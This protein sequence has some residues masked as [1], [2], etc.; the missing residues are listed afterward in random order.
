MITCMVSTGPAD[1]N[2]LTRGATAGGAGFAIHQHLPRLADLIP[3]TVKAVGNDDRAELGRIQ[4]E[5]EKTPGLLIRDSSPVLAAGARGLAAA[6]RKVD[7]FVG[8]AKETIADARAALVGPDGE[9]GILSGERLSLPK[10]R[11]R[12]P[13]ATAPAPSGWDPSPA[14]AGR[15][16]SAEGSVW[17]A[18]AP[19]AADRRRQ[20]WAEEQRRQDAHWARAAAIRKETEEREAEKVRRYARDYWLRQ[21]RPEAALPDFDAIIQPG[22]YAHDNYRRMMR[23]EGWTGPSGA[24]APNGYSEALAELP[25]ENGGNADNDYDSVLHAVEELEAEQKRQAEEKRRRQEAAQARIRAEAEER[26]RQEAAQAR[27]RAEAE[28]RRRQ[29]AVQAR[30]ITPGDQCYFTD[31]TCGY[32]TAYKYLMKLRNQNELA[33]KTRAM[34]QRAPGYQRVHE[35]ATTATAEAVALQS[36]FTTA[37]REC[38]N[39]DLNSKTAYEQESIYATMVAAFRATLAVLSKENDPVLTN[40]VAKSE[41]VS[42]FSETPGPEAHLAECVPSSAH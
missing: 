32:S 13:A 15:S 11:H 16:E 21:G 39:I 31:D 40:I 3:K 18:P 35:A 10:F 7:R 4:L 37:A 5:V 26:R 41:F 27:I 6:K 29:E 1:A 12:A 19:S 38:A 9:G 25:D 42:F 34:D 14:P 33:E 20:A 30:R 22:S 2:M 23:N 24:G 17:D 36:A 28:E 8:N